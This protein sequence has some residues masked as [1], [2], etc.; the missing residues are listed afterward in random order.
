MKELDGVAMTPLEVKD[1][2]SLGKAPVAN[3]S[4]PGRAPMNRRASPRR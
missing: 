2:L 3:G 4:K 1:A